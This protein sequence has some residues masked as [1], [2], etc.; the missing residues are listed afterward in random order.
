MAADEEDALPAY[1][2][3]DEHDD[4]DFEDDKKMS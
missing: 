2:N 3:D 1:F 4:L